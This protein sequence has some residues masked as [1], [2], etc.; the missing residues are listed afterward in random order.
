[1]NNIRIVNSNIKIY[2]I[3]FIL[4]IA[5]LSACTNYEGKRIFTEEKTSTNDIKETSVSRNPKIDKMKEMLIGTNLS[6]ILENL[7]IAYSTQYYHVMFIRQPF[8]CHGCVEK[9]KQ[10]LDSLGTLLGKEHITH[11]L[12]SG[13]YEVSAEEVDVKIISD[14]TL[15]DRLK[16]TYSPIFLLIDNTSGKVIDVYFPQISEDEWYKNYFLNTSRRKFS[17]ELVTDK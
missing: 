5:S 1:M 15:R 7:D 14:S 4:S 8:D 12:H 16:H 11:V 9:G 6:D 17:L 13:T 10:V 3:G 2:A